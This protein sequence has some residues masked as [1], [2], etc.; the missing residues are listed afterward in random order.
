MHN[1]VL[2]FDKLLLESRHAV[3]FGGAGVSVE[4]GIPDFRSQDGLY[5]QTW[6]EAPE[7]ILSATYFKAHTENF[8]RFY[9]EKM[10]F[11]D[12]QPNPA[13]KALALMEKE[14]L[15]DAVIT[16]NIDGLHQKAG[17]KQVV[18]LHGTTHRNFCRR[19]GRF[20]TL[21]DIL[22]TQGVPMCPCGGVIKPDVT[23]Y[24]EAL[25]AQA[26]EDASYYIDKA[27]LLIIGGTSL[28]VYPAAGF[29]R[30]F[31][32]KIVII[33]KSPTPLD[34]QADLLIPHPIGQFLGAWEEMH[35]SQKV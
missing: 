9:R 23:L 25:P 2:A 30:Y 21:K 20:Y 10:L 33:N 26:M 32:G 1:Q 4:S 27:D 3:F 31:D 24:E 28:S 16:Q 22:N 34:R 15:I 5:N 18:E 14:K 12:A 17:S 8:Y 7:T 11:P 6:Q 29:V 19:C 13:H 35:K